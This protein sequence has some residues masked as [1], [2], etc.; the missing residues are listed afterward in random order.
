MTARISSGTGSK[1]DYGTPWDLFRQIQ[2]HFFPRSFV[3]D[4]AANGVNHKCDMWYGPDGIMPDSLVTPWPKRGW[5]F[6]N[7]PYTD[8][9]PWYR[10]CAE[11]Y[12][13]GVRIVSLVPMDS[14]T[15]WFDYVPGNAGIWHLQGRVKFDGA[16]QSGA[17]DSALHIWSPE[18]VGQFRV[19]NWKQDRFLI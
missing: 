2:K 7:P 8:I 18:F 19:W 9:G 12:A 3:L 14:A 17:K 1:Q 5:L 16:D 11:E 10:K 4:L 13:L 6:L 15:S